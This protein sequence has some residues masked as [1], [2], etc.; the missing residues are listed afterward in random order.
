MLILCIAVLVILKDVPCTVMTEL[1]QFMYQG[2]VNV[3]H[4]E[5][6]S[7]MKIAQQLQIKGLHTSSKQEVHQSQ[8]HH[9]AQKSPSSPV[10]SYSSKSAIDNYSNAFHSS[11]LIGQKRAALDYSSGHSESATSKKHLK[12]SS[13][14][15]D[16]DISAESMENLSSEDGF[17]IPQISMIESGRFDLSNVKRESGESP[18]SN[19]NLAAPYNFEYSR[20]ANAGSSTG[21]GSSSSS[22]INANHMDIPTGGNITMLSSTSLLHGNCIFNRNNTVATQQGMKTYW[23]CKSYRI[24]MCRA[25]CITHQSRVISATGMHNHQPHMKGSYQ[26]SEF[27]QNGSATNV[28]N[29]GH[30]ISVSMRLPF[31]IPATVSSTPATENQSSAQTNI[32]LP[33]TSQHQD[34]SNHMVGETQSQE[35]NHTHVHHHLPPV[36]Q[37]QHHHSEHMPQS[38]TSSSLL[39]NM[40]Q[41]AMSHNNL[42]NITNMVP[43]LNPMQS[44]THLTHMHSSQLSNELHPTPSQGHENSQNLHSPDSPRNSMHHAQL[45]RAHMSVDANRMPPNHSQS[46]SSMH[47]HQQHHHHH[48]ATQSSESNDHAVRLSPPNDTQL[49]QDQITP[50]SNPA[51]HLSLGSDMNNSQSF[52]LEHI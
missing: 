2:V 32:L 20:L 8:S 1:L 27:V 5:L 40:M 3:K 45:V 34:V 36:S 14:S 10:G 50:D 44:H 13:D 24:T 38:S 9:H 22:A 25:R 46:G 33:V 21:A 15:V 7:F 23:L 28:S 18:S 17:P 4:T 39:Q 42:M 51:V 37:S 41:N 11:S 12:R 43:I 16:N 49:Q 48:R 52:K 19:R 30:S 6:N 47:T 29:N 26:N 31:V 35:P